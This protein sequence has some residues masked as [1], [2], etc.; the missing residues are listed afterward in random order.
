MEKYLV[1]KDICATVE[2]MKTVGHKALETIST[3]ET[4]F[5]DNKGNSL[6]LVKS[7]WIEPEEIVRIGDNMLALAKQRKLDLV[8]RPLLKVYG[9]D[10]HSN[11]DVGFFSL[12]DSIDGYKFSGQTAMSSPMTSD[13]KLL[14]HA[15]NKQLDTKF[16]AILVN[17]YADGKDYIGAHGDNE[18][19]LDKS[20]V[21]GLSFGATRTF[22]IR[23]KTSKQMKLNH[24]WRNG[25]VLVM[26]GP[27]FQKTYT[28][29]IPK[30]TLVK[31][32]RLS[33]TWR[34]HRATN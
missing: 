15:L 9:K 24:P 13:M 22:R 25:T 26:S 3:L 6:F 31:Q 7:K 1:K 10:V 21:A 27:S 18:L 19:H 29:E 20:M 17:Y 12:D 16:N 14:T 5:S 11:R 2:D 28:H 33:L 23:D 32:P 8:H 4:I 34:T 30:E